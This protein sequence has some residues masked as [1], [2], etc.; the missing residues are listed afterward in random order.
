V[1]W[2]G[3]DTSFEVTGLQPEREYQLRVRTVSV[4]GEGDAVSTALTIRTAEYFP[5][6]VP[7]VSVRQVRDGPQCRIELSWFDG[8][9]TRPSVRDN[10]RLVSALDPPPILYRIECLRC[11]PEDV[12]DHTNLPD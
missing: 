6:P 11:L 8:L 5:P 7:V 1:V 10:H 3:L 2:S 12:R 4:I 9:R